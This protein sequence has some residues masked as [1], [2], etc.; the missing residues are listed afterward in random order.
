MVL[1][2]VNYLFSLGFFVFVFKCWAAP[3]AYGGSQA[4]GQIGAAA[5]NL[6]HSHSNVESEP[7]LQPTPQLTAMPDPPPTKPGI[8][9]GSSWIL[10]GFVTTEPQWEL[11][12]GFFK[13]PSF[14]AW[15]GG[16]SIP[17]TNCLLVACFYR[18]LQNFSV[19]KQGSENSKQGTIRE[20]FGKVE[21]EG[22][23]GDLMALEQS[24]VFFS[25]LLYP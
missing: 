10:V 7:H 25:H 16:N 13:F 9:P 2:I 17:G 23:G 19:L 11:L 8:E 14:I 6:H 22:K 3:A 5:A 20:Y 12:F 4:R 24:V 18:M 1:C 21:G 15:D